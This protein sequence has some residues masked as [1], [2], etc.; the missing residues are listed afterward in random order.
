LEVL[1]EQLDIPVASIV[2]VQDVTPKQ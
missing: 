1:Q 2:E